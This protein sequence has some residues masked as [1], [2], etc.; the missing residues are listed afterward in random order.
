MRLFFLFLFLGGTCS[1]VSQNLANPSN[2]LPSK[3]EV[4][5]FDGKCTDYPNP[6]DFIP[7]KSEPKPDTLMLYKRL[8][9]IFPNSTK[10][11]G[12]IN[13]RMFTTAKDSL[14]KAAYI[15]SSDYEAFRI[16]ALEAIKYLRSL[17]ALDY[18]DKPIDC[19]G[20]RPIYFPIK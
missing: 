7:L 11:S 15:E 2:T 16:P 12:K 10:L 17:P 8:K 18:P 13:I 4:D 5:W 3:C 14:I 20:S 9:A 19:W 6:Y 1:C